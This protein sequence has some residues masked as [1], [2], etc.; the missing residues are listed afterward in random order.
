MGKYLEKIDIATLIADFA[1]YETIPADFVAKV[2]A[3]VGEE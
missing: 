2:K 1:N 3:Q